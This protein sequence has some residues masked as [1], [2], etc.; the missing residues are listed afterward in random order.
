MGINLLGGVYLGKKD[1][2]EKTDVFEIRPP[3]VY[4]VPVLCTNGYP[5]EITVKV[6]DR[7][8]DG[9]LLAKPTQNKGAFVYSPT[10]GKVVSIVDKF[11]PTGIKCP[12]VVIK[13]DNK[14]DEHTFAE[15]ENKTPQE[16]L[17][18][19]AVSGIVD[20]NFGGSPTYLRYTLN[21]IEKKFTLNV[22]MSNTDP[23]LTANEALAI[24]RTAQVVGGAKYFAKLLA[25]DQ[26]VFVFT[27][28]ARYA[29]KILKT[30]L[31][32]N[33]PQLKYKIK[34]ISNNY[35]SDNFALLT[36][37]F[38]Q[39]R[40][41]FVEMFG[42]KAFIEDAITCYSFYN[43]VEHGKPV[44]YRTITIS[45]NNIIRKGNYIVKNGTSFQHILEVVGAKQKDRPFKVLNGGIMMGF[46]EYSTDIS[47]NPETQ[48]VTFVDDTE[49]KT[50]KESPCVNCGKCVAVCPM[51]LLPNV[52]DDLCIRKKTFDAERY[53]I[54]S[55]IDCG[56]CSF[57]CPAKR[58][59]T[60]R[61]S[62]TRRQI[63][64]R[65]KK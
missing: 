30:Y 60:Q 40:A 1:D 31:K 29:R 46:A 50:A 34:L 35:P 63:E 33:E 58:Y 15:M 22:V 43:A 44:N 13:N 65:G 59:L 42:K 28:R 21:A 27:A 61:I 12:H 23:Y 64:K 49:F 6:G 37:R 10:S 55:C 32:K 51:N 39:K 11:T 48:S 26:I 2:T 16:L 62:L 45:G 56:C 9:S 14:L 7:V 41:Y 24:N 8:K 38:K 54:K 57:V 3:E 53:G 47:S 19:L 36:E 20:A 25:S 4:S 5:V 52:L 17:K 18:R